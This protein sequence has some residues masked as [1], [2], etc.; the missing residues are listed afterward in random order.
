MCVPI[1]EAVGVG[2]ASTIVAGRRISR[3]WG[4]SWSSL[5]L[6]MRAHTSALGAWV[7]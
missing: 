4:A 5:S 2:G 7:M 3:S 1:D 6:R